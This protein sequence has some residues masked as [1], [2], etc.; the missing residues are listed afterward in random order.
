MAPDTVVHTHKRPLDPSLLDLNE[1]ETQFFKSLTGIQ[2]EKELEEHIIL[3]QAKAY[4]VYGYPCIQA[5]AF[6]NLTIS[7]QPGYR[8][9]LQLLR[10]RP[11][12][13]LLDIGCCFG[14]DL[15]K[16][17]VDGWP[18][19]NTIASDLRSEFW[20]CGHE[21][22]N[23]TPKT[24]PAAFIAGDSFSSAL[25]EPRE[26]FYSE[27]ATERPTDLRTLKSLTPLQGHISAIHASSFFHLFDEEK[28]L[29]LAKQLATLL[30]PE[31]GSVIFGNHGG[32][33]VK[34]LR[35][36]V[37]SSS[38]GHMFCHSPESWS[39]L[40]D[41]QVFE[42]GAVKVEAKLVERVRRPSDPPGIIFHWLSWSVIRL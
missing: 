3:V 42:K 31:P 25:I 40:W 36:E 32:R 37:V 11:G 21:L 24:F 34:G 12:A 23:S 7:Q 6:T 28:Q 15:R 26:P 41:G 14:N 18:V 30:S 29:A 5:F 38:G 20:E 17:V 16:A 22:F 19:E 13:I 35:T 33:P 39:D 1:D 27:P 4:E 9:V 10:R 8:R 2:N